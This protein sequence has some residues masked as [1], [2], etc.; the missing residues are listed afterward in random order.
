M[1]AGPLYGQLRSGKRVSLP[2]GV[3]VLPEHV[4]SG[5]GAG[6]LVLIVDCC[7]LEHLHLLRRH[8]LMQQ[9]GGGAEGRVVDV[10]IHLTP[11]ELCTSVEYAAWAS[12][13]PSA[14]AHCFV[15]IAPQAIAS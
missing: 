14:V 2:G 15:D 6:E 5:G 13:L 12:S 8:R 11:A 4:M 3:E 10:V 7:T 1:L 9:H